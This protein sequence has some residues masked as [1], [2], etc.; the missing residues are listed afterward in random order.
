MVL[1]R[2]LSDFLRAGRP[3]L[4]QLVAEARS[5]FPAFDTD[6]FAS[7]LQSSLDPVVAAVAA[8]IPDRTAAVAWAGYEIALEIIGHDLPGH[9]RRRELLD[10]I[11]QQVLPACARLLASQ[12]PEL[13][14]SLCNAAVY[15]AN[16]QDVRPAE[17]LLGMTRLAGCAETE[18]QLHS[19]GQLLA[20]RTGLPQF[21]LGAIAA[22]D[23]LP[24]PIALAALGL[25]G[26][27]NWSHVRQQLLADR[28]FLLALTHGQ[29]PKAVKFGGFAGL[30]GVFSEPP[31]V[32]PCA[33]GFVVRSG[34]SC[35]LLLADACGTALLPA[36]DADYDNAY[37]SKADGVS[38][39]GSRLHLGQHSVDLDLPEG[40]ISIA[41]NGDTVAVSSPF[42][43]VIRLLPIV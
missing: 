35:H 7:F 31:Q 13:I 32:R 36:T 2:P 40:H 15:L 27:D 22:A 6:S 28:W 5:R 23:Q 17:W 1:S 30:G 43:H 9:T 26:L 39:R 29:A 25:D 33:D 14:R 3:Q 42:S 8:S 16:A 41:C 34:Q 38:L 12:P 10:G 24:A 4:N 18:A 37:G 19:L 21:R 20:W 11:W